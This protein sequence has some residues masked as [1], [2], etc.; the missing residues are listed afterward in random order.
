MIGPESVS[1]TTKCT[2]APCRF[3]AGFKRAAMGM[4]PLE[5]RQQRR[6]DVQHAPAPARDEPWREEPHEAGKADEI[7]ALRVKL[8]VER[9][10]EAF[11]VVAE[12]P[13]IDQRG[14]NSR[15]ARA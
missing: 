6:V 2:V 5:L 3:D 10:F 4:Q 9:A 14:R 11:A 8:G 15:L 12:R 1:G 13:V 7:D